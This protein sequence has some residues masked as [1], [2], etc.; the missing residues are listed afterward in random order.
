MSC[1][2]KNKCDG[3]NCFCCKV[4]ENGRTEYRPSEQYLQGGADAVEFIVDNIIFPM[5]DELDI[6]IW[7]H[8]DYIELADTWVKAVKSNLYP[9]VKDCDDEIKKY[10]KEW[11]TERFNK[12]LK[13]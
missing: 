7:E 3:N 12:N 9:E 10:L 13:E 4:G 5:L 2:L 8:I 1:S 11:I 6:G